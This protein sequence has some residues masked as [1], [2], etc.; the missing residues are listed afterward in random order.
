MP[1]VKFATPSSFGSRNFKR[2]STTLL[3]RIST[4]QTGASAVEFALVLPIFLLFMAG[5]IQFSTAYFVQA[6]MADVA[7]D[8]A[9]RVMVG[10]IDA[11]A[12]RT[13]AKNQLFSWGATFEV[14]VTDTTNETAVDITVPLSDVS[15][16][17]IFGFFKSGNLQ[18]RAEFSK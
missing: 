4:E 6:Q 13:Y 18:A 1:F 15:L 14:A 5:I 10:Q 3:A 16:M 11:T 2:R 7:R 17:N 8:T 9:R 12:G